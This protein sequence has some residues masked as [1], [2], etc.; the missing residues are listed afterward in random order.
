[1][2]AICSSNKIETIGLGIL[3]L[4]LVGYRTK[5]WKTLTHLQTVTIVCASLEMKRLPERQMQSSQQMQVGPQRVVIVQGAIPQELLPMMQ[6]QPVYVQ[7][8][9]PIETFHSGEHELP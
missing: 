2:N 6:V 7:Q 9:Q 4:S 5:S 1:M 8:Q 3:S